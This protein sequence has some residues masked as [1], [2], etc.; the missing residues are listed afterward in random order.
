MRHIDKNGREIP[1]TRQELQDFLVANPDAVNA[2][3]IESWS[4]GKL[5]AYVQA[6]GIHA[7]KLPKD[8][9]L[10]ATAFIK[11]RKLEG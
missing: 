2:V 3:G 4:I 6:N 7:A 10:A 1:F 8:V 5:R 9:L 11:Y